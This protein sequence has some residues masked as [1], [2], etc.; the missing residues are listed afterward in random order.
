VR[1][2][3]IDHRTHGPRAS[4]CSDPLRIRAPVQCPTPTSSRPPDPADLAAAL[5]FALRY[6]GRK[7]VHNADELMAEIVARHLVQHLGQT[8]LGRHPTAFPGPSAALPRRYPGSNIL[9]VCLQK[10]CYKPLILLARPDGFEPPTLGF[11]GPQ[12][13]DT[14]EKLGN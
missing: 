5:A 6:Q 14:V 1:T 10:I 2:H 7:R 13:V 11:E 8:H 12:Y 9:R 3:P 4:S